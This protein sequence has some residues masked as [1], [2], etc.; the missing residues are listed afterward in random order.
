[1]SLD[2]AGKSELRRVLRARRGRL[3]A[4]EQRRAALELPR[5]VATLP[6]WQGARRIALYLAADGELD[7]GPLAKQGRDSGKQ[8]Y[9]PV[10][11][12]G[13]ALE[14]ALWDEAAPLSTNRYRIPEPPSEAPRC[15]PHRLHIMFIPLVGWDNRGG[16]LGMG[17]GFYDRSLAGVS[18]P[19]RVGLAHDCQEVDR[20]PL[21]PWDVPLD[22]VATG[23]R[24]IDCRE[25]P[26][27]GAED[28]SPG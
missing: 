22:Y 7:T 13:D 2:R 9:L 6:G 23:S 27:A 17:G 19:L 1:M 16:R 20:I 25:P 24:L 10:L 18:G 8:L 5:L 11:S 26:P 15:E 3:G 21:E 12:H 14:F 28:V 4:R